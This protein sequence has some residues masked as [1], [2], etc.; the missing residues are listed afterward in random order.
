MR[1]PNLYQ[2]SLFFAVLVL[3]SAA[4]Y[5]G[6]GAQSQ[7]VMIVLPVLGAG[8]DAARVVRDIEEIEGRKDR[9]VILL[10]DQA[11]AGRPQP[12]VPMFAPPGVIEMLVKAGE[13]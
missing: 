10:P 12:A 9:G 11:K 7:E 1:Q 13:K 2:L 3:A 5:V 8:V 4:P 6:G